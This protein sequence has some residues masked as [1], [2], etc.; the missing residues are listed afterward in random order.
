MPEGQERG[1]GLDL[2]GDDGLKDLPPP[3]LDPPTLRVLDPVPEAADLII[4]LPLEELIRKVPRDQEHAYQLI[5]QLLREI[6]VAVPAL[7]L[8]NTG[9]KFLRKVGRVI[10]W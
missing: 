1:A 9:E 3:S 8:V 5:R 2:I 4:A 6:P 7:E 10:T